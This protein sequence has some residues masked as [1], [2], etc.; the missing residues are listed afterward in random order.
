[1]ALQ[2][3]DQNTTCKYVVVLIYNDTDTLVEWWLRARS[4]FQGKHKRGF[5]SV[6]IG[7]AW[8]LWKQRN[9]KVFNRPEQVKDYSEL[10]RAIL[11]E[12]R[13]WYNAG[14]GAGGLDRFVRDHT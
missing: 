8:M 6:V 9:A 12:I 11:D 14:V 5:D 10:A 4:G 7:A 13:E 3:V 2:T 1:M